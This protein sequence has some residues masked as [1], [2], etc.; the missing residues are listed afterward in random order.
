[1]INLELPQNILCSTEDTKAL[2]AVD[3][4]CFN[5]L[6]NKYTIQNHNLHIHI[7]ILPGLWCILKSGSDYLYLS[8]SS[9]WK[10]SNLKRSFTNMMGYN[11][12]QKHC[13]KST[14]QMESN[15]AAGTFVGNQMTSLT[16]NT[17]CTLD[18]PSNIQYIPVC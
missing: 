17:F 11:V 3:W 7:H 13:T 6:N 2:T 4:I 15:V 18:K 1:M 12:L 10:F 8:V 5:A 16:K 9:T 14:L